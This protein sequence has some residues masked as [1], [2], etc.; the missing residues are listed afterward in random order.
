VPCP[1]VSINGVIGRDD[2]F[3]HKA[4]KMGCRHYLGGLLEARERKNLTEMSKDAVGV[5]YHPLHNF[6]T[7][8]PHR[9]RVS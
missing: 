8:A 4:Q 6:L 1:H 3:T 7:E 9:R 5:T 2:V